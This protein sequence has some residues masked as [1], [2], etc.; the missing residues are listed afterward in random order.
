MVSD[1]FYFHPYLGKIPIL[2][3]IFQMGWNHQLGQLVPFPFQPIKNT[4]IQNTTTATEAAKIFHLLARCVGVALVDWWD[5]GVLLLNWEPPIMFW[6]GQDWGWQWMILDDWNTRN[7]CFP[8]IMVP[9]NGWFIMKN[10]I[11]MDDLGVPLFLE[12]PK[13]FQIFV[14]FIWEPCSLR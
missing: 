7:G 4:T 1:I 6:L 14:G 3:N 9:Q 5:S 11:K 13:W 10:P 8:K 12:T 2:T